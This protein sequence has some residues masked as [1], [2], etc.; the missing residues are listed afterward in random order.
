M[1]WRM[2]LI[3]PVSA[4]LLLSTVL[5]AQYTYNEYEMQYGKPIEVSLDSL[6]E[7]PELYD[8]KAVTT[9]GRLEPIILPESRLWALGGFNGRAVIVPFRDASFRF[10]D[11]GLRWTGRDIEVTGVVSIGQDPQRR[12]RTAVISFWAYLG[13]PDEKQGPPPK[14]GC[15]SR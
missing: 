10:Q 2:T 6:L 15:S 5:H 7:M 11:D 9:T 4:V 13:P 1:G 12:M 14:S 8:G 3:G